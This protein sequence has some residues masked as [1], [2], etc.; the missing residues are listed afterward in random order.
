MLRY[1]PS[2][3]PARYSSRPARGR[4]LALAVGAGGLGV[5]VI[6]GVVLCLAGLAHPG[7]DPAQHSNDVVVRARPARPQAVSGAV[8][9]ARDALA[10]APMPDTGTGAEFGRAQVSTRDAGAPIV[11]PPA[12]GVDF[13]GVATG[14]PHTPQGALAQ[15]AAID[16]TALQSAS[17]PGV[18]AVITAWAAPGG[19]TTQS[20]SGVRAMASLLG[21]ARVPA[22]G[23]PGLRVAVRAAMALVKGQVGDDFVVGCVDFGVDIVTGAAMTD[24]VAVDCQRMLWQD[25]RW[26]IGP[27]PEPAPAPQVWPDTDAALDAGYRDVTGT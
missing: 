11:L 18:R 24:T 3:A 13:L 1:R 20:W 6:A 10:A 26:I 27:G 9:A 5:L 22:A 14:Y 16:T 17:L 19:P 21:S 8:A 4:L 7:Q 25:G 2:S 12:R 15:L 23:S